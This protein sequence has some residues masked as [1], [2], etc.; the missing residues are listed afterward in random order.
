MS[1]TSTTPAKKYAV[2]LADGT[3]EDVST[4]K[5]AIAKGEA[6]GQAFTVLSPRGFEVYVGEAAEPKS[7]TL[8]AAHL[9]VGQVVVGTGKR[10]PV[11]KIAKVSVGKKWVTVWDAEGKCF[12]YFPTAGTMVEVVTD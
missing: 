11:R 1:G 9:K 5:A 12:G 6:S 7:T 2:V 10:N 4:K 3:S 8:S